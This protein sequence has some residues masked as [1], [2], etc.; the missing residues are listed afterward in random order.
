MDTIY[1]VSTILLLPFTP[2]YSVSFFMAGGVKI[3]N[4]TPL[5]F[6]FY[7][8]SLKNFKGNLEETTDIINRDNGVVRG[9]YV[10]CFVT[11]NINN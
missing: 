5:A 7:V 2:I 4:F 10:R 3:K 11:I 1:R 9:L 8:P 6:S